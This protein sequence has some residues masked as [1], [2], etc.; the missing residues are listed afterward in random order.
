[1]SLGNVLVF[2]APKSLSDLLAKTEDQL[3]L[4]NLA[5]AGGVFIAFQVTRRIHT[6]YR[7]DHPKGYDLF[8]VDPESRLGAY[9]ANVGY[10]PKTVGNSVHHAIWLIYVVFGTWGEEKIGTVF[11]SEEARDLY[12]EPEGSDADRK[13]T[14]IEYAYW[15]SR[16]G[17]F[18]GFLG[19]LFSPRIRVWLQYRVFYKDFAVA[20]SLENFLIK[21]FGFLR[22]SWREK[23]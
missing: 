10:G 17:T 20:I 14:E 1:M 6:L 15:Q 7:V 3:T 19:C 23:K 22:S 2:E 16:K 21:I 11:N 18:G 5:V 13:I 8:D 9:K 12:P 4:K